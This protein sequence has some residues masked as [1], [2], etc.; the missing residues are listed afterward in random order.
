MFIFCFFTF[1]GG[2]VFWKVICSK[3]GCRTK[4]KVKSKVKA[5]VKVEATTKC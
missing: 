5:K 1:L 2:L 3:F 4:T